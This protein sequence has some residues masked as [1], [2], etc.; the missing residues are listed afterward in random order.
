MTPSL[1]SIHLLEWL[2]E[3]RETFFALLPIIKGYDDTVEHPDERD[4]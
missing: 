4:E 1:D 3:L 2:A